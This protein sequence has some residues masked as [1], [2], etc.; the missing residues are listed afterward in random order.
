MAAT[1]SRARV[2]PVFVLTGLFVGFHAVLVVAVVGLTQSAEPSPQP[3]RPPVTVASARPADVAPPPLA[4]EAGDE[5]PPDLPGPV[6]ALADASSPAPV[7]PP[8]ADDAG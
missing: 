8:A 7:G 1:R 5:T 3:N 4:R 6:L 2:R